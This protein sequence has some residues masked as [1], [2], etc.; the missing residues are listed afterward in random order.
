MLG[1]LELWVWS[2]DGNTPYGSKRSD[3]TVTQSNRWD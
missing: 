2:E 3:S 1:P